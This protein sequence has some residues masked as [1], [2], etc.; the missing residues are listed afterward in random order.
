MRKERK[1]QKTLSPSSPTPT[2][3]SYSLHDTINSIKSY[4]HNI[5]QHNGTRPSKYPKSNNDKETIEWLEKEL[6]VVK[7]KMKE[8]QECLET[9]SR[10]T[11]V[12]KSVCSKNLSLS[13]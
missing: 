3:L 1:R 10:I 12:D 8:I 13:E 6:L 4:L 5:N 11:L 2:L 7:N 9:K